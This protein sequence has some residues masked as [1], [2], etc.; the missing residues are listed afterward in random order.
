MTEEVKVHPSV[1]GP[2]LHTTQE[3]H[4]EGARHIQV[5]NV[6]CQVKDGF[7]DAMLADGRDA[8]HV[9]VSDLGQE[10]RI[11]ARNSTHWAHNKRLNFKSQ[12]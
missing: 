3:A 12:S 11:L 4:V 1:C 5:A 10:D 8:C 6:K 9:W 7:H 2:A